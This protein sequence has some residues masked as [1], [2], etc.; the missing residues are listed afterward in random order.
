[1]SKTAINKSIP[2][3]LC[4]E[5]NVAG[6]HGSTL[7]RLGADELFYMQSRGISE[8]EA[9]VMMKK[10]KILSVAGKIPNEEVRQKIESWL[11]LS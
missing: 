1:M 9:K 3:I 8:D 6:T 10:A 2:M 7:G 11:E 5:E 4:D